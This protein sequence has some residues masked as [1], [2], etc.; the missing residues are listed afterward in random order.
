MREAIWEC[1]GEGKQNAAG[2]VFFIAHNHYGPHG[3][4]RRQC[5]VGVR[6]LRMVNHHDAHVLQWNM[7]DWLAIALQ[8]QLL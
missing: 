1:W 5:G 4:Q 6:R 3:R 7:G 2:Q 8:N